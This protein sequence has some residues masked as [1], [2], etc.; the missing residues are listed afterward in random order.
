MVAAVLKPRE[1]KLRR[2]YI[3]ALEACCELATE[4]CNAIDCVATDVGGARSPAVILKELGPA[5]ALVESKGREL[6]QL[7]ERT[8]RR[9]P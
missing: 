7:I 8:K 5:T 9:K 1:G 3:R 4:F 6:H 2:D